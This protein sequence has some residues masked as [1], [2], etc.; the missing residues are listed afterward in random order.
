MNKK[1]VIVVSLVKESSEMSNEEI[2]KE[3]SEE[4]QKIPV[5]IPWLEKLLMV[6]ATDDQEPNGECLYLEKYVTVLL[7][8]L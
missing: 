3:I 6:K 5:A 7:S 8:I 2:E 1:V 4:L